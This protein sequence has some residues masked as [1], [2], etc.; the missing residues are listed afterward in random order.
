MSCEVRHFEGSARP[1]E[2]YRRGSH[3]GSPT[4][5]VPPR[6]WELSCAFLPLVFPYPGVLGLVKPVVIV[7]DL[8]V[9]GEVTIVGLSNLVSDV[10]EHP[11]V[12]PSIH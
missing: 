7:L 9:A 4:L 12:P 11:F 8:A 10:P 2:A 3:W 5:A 6:T 1:T